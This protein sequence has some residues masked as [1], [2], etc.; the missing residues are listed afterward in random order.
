[1]L[2]ETTHIVTAHQYR[3]IHE[4]YIVWVY[5]EE[6]EIQYLCAFTSVI[7]PRQGTFAHK[8]Q[9]I[10]RFGSTPLAGQTPALEVKDVGRSVLINSLSSLFQLEPSPHTSTIIFTKPL[11]NL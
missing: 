2:N 4:V 5:C 6:L 3:R 11:L 9:E 7:P 8:Y 10:C 1:M